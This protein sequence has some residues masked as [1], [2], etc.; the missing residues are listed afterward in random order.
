MKNLLIALAVVGLTYSSADAQTTKSCGVVTTGK[1]CKMSPNKKTTSCYKTD[2]AENY[3]VCKGDYGYF[4]CC[5]TPGQNN[6]THPY[7]N[8]IASK[9]NTMQFEPPFVATA[10]PERDMT[11]QSQSYAYEVNSANSYEGYYTDKNFIKVCYFGDNV[12]LNNQNPYK[13]CPSPQSEGPEVNRQRNVNVSNP[14]SL[15]PLA[16]RS[17]E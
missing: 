11:P 9:P 4:I 14:V 13:G 5:E 10:P 3:K 12:A 17:Q 16:G 1:V 2:F 8:T 6:T 7:M 15:P